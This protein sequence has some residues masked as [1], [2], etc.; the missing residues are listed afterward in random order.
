MTYRLDLAVAAASASAPVLAAQL[1]G[2]APWWAYAVGPALGLLLGRLTR[3]GSAAMRS[4]AKKRRER[5][6]ALL[7]DD[8]PS[9]DDEGREVLARAEL[10]EIAA[11]GLSGDKNGP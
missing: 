6:E 9:N 10:Y 2:D 3:M 8:D 7:A 1:P 5:A 4:A 11:D